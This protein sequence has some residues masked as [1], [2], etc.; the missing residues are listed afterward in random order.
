MA[1]EVELPREIE[2]SMKSSKELD[3]LVRKRIERDIIETIK[4]DIFI[5]KI[6]DS[7]LKRSI[8]SVEDVNELDHKMKRGM[9][10]KMG[11][12]AMATVEIQKED[13]LMAY[14][15]EQYKKLQKEKD[16]YISLDEYCAKRG[17]K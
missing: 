12:R 16:Q 5:S 11:W 4:N 1:I 3:V 17:I 13:V 7:L 14:A 2:L 8:L 9:M 6:F 15:D 10:E